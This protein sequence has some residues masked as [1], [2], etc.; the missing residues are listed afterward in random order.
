MR[1][2]IQDS[3]RGDDGTAPF[4]PERTPPDNATNADRLAAF[5]GRTRT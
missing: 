2:A 3:F 4:G 1:G 5:L